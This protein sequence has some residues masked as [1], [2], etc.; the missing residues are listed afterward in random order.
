MLSPTPRHRNVARRKLR[1]PSLDSPSSIEQLHWNSTVVKGELVGGEEVAD[2]ASWKTVDDLVDVDAYS[3]GVGDIATP[4]VNCRAPMV[5][6]CMLDSS[7]LAAMGSSDRRLRRQRQR[8]AAR[9]DAS[10]R[11]SQGSVSGSEGGR[12]VSRGNSLNGDWPE[13]YQM[14]GEPVKFSLN[15]PDGTNMSRPAPLQQA[16]M[17]DESDTDCVSVASR[18]PSIGRMSI[19]SSFSTFSAPIELSATALSASCQVAGPGQVLGLA[20][21]GQMPDAEKRTLT[22]SWTAS[23][24]LPSGPSLSSA[25]S[26]DNAMQ[27]QSPSL[28]DHVGHNCSQPCKSERSKLVGSGSQEQAV[29]MASQPEHLRNGRYV[30]KLWR[31]SLAQAFCL[32]FFTAASRDGQLSGIFAS[33]DL[34]YLGISRWDTLLSIN[35]VE[36]RTVEECRNMLRQLRSLVLT[37]QSKIR[38]SL[39][40]VPK[41]KMESLPPLD[42]MLLTI[43]KDTSRGNSEFTLTIKRRSPKLQVDLQFSKSPSKSK[44]QG[45][46]LA[47]RDMPQLEILAG[48]QLLSVNGIQSP[49]SKTLK[50]FLEVEMV[51]NLTLR[52]SSGKGKPP[53]SVQLGTYRTPDEELSDSNLVVEEVC[54]QNFGCCA[55][56]PQL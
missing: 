11:S 14:L 50:Q 54:T 39:E 26:F 5:P 31:A 9:G 15:G 4:E 52:R 20:R 13:C 6:S 56:E 41:P 53:P 28:R 34:P 33:H 7:Q 12:S 2:P 35:G 8:H 21:P 19:D 40:P 43:R 38:L 1:A 17:D 37:F 47:S 24:G 55:T 46:L 51:M 30:V 42:V 3:P 25:F 48:D 23:T 29:L 22:Q 16:Y 18:A 49:N 32:E 36:P 44:D 10:E 27:C 45:A